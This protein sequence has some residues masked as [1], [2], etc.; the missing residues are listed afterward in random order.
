MVGASR[1]NSDSLSAATAVLVRYVAA[2]TPLETCANP[3]VGNVAGV[4]I[5]KLLAD[6]VV[7]CPS[8]T[9]PACRTRESHACGF[10][11]RHATMLEASVTT[12]ERRQ[13]HPMSNQMDEGRPAPT[14]QPTA[15]PS[16]S[17]PATRATSPT[18]TT[19]A[20][21]PSPWHPALNE[22]APLEV[23]TTGWAELTAPFDGVPAVVLLT[24]D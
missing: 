1:Q 5:A 3:V 17:L 13:E 19:T 20:A 18:D 4:P 16:W 8:S 15:A 22:A 21:G 24:R 2:V 7:H 11:A 12:A 6:N 10:P 23:T 9:V 14:G